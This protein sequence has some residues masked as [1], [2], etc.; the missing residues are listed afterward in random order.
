MKPLRLFVIA[1]FSFNISGLFATPFDMIPAGDPVLRD[2]RF[3]SLESGRPFLSFTPPLS[4]A[5]IEQFLNSLDPALLSNPAQHAYNRVRNRLTPS[6]PF[7]FSSN[8]FTALANIN[9]TFEARVR[10]NPEI[11]WYPLYPNVPPFLSMPI[12]LCFSNFFQLYVE[13]ILAAN[14]VYYTRPERFGVNVPYGYHHF[15]VNMPL[16]AFVAAG[17]PW[18]N[19]QL[20]RDRLFWGTGHTG[21]LTFSDNSDFFEFMRLSAFSDFF[22]YSLTV[23]Q[24]PLEVT[25]A[26]Y[27]RPFQNPYDP[28]SMMLTTQ[29]H[30]YLHRI[31]LNL[32]NRVSIGVMEGI[33]AGNSGLELRFLNPLVIFHSLFSW[34]DYEPW[35]ENPEMGSMIGSFFSIDLNWNITRNL[36]FHGQFV[37]NEFALPG[38]L[39]ADGVEPP[40]ALGYLA[41]LSYTHS[42]NNWGSVFFFEFIYTDPYLFILSSPFA[43]FI[44][45][46]RISPDYLQYYFIGYP[47]DTMAF[48]LGTRFFNNDASLNFTGYLSW[49]SRG[50]HNKDGITWNWERTQEAF[51][52]RT[53]T[54]VAENQLV[55]SFA[56]QWKLSPFFTLNGGFTGIFSINNR[57]LSGSNAI[58]G[59]AMF[60]VSFRY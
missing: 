42:F 12:R 40:N 22:K 2:L 10:F 34:H 55:A 26:L 8:N 9:S 16:R 24:M 51:D 45:M 35:P 3:L 15:D 48:T 6:A 19:F 59:Q 43:S 53:P 58:G 28:S 11:S 5:E 25:E 36:A 13:P 44:Q 41:G 20:G 18:W 37:M 38:E 57:H 50:E 31:D 54:G 29:R 46:R 27:A 52:A 39:R 33:M 47:R 7:R 14:P 32:F 30:F 4:P 49:V 17:G 1:L 56:A 21:S 60:S 23:S